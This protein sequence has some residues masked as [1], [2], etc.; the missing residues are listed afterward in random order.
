MNTEEQI[1]TI[2]QTTIPAI[3]PAVFCSVFITPCGASAL[4]VV[5]SGTLCDCFVTIV[6]PFV[7]DLAVE[8]L[9]VCNVDANLEDDIGLI[10]GV[11]SSENIVF[12]VLN[13]RR[14]VCLLDDM[15]IDVILWVLLVECIGVVV[16]L[17]FRDVDVSLTAD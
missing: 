3:S 4:T 12:V 6:C 17:C 5:L 1:R 13:E 9:V 8:V 16:T 2:E 7:F 10:L 11:C 15:V 14:D